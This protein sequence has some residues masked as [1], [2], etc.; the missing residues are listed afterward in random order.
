MLVSYLHMCELS[1]P[2]LH[3]GE[4]ELYEFIFF[5]S[6]SIVAGKEE[7]LCISRAVFTLQVLRE[8]FCFHGQQMGLSA[9]E[10]WL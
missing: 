6:N 2:A 3:R 8:N 10:A 1:T 4:W 7:S 5:L 9:W